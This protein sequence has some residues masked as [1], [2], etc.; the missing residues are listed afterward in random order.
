MAKEVT[1]AGARADARVDARGA[2]VGAE[3]GSIA[4]CLVPFPQSPRVLIE[5]RAGSMLGKRGA[6]GR[7]WFWTF[8][9][10]LCDILGGLEG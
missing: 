3:S 6:L 7:A 8:L 10:Q 1:L 9:D 4:P 2:S 5:A